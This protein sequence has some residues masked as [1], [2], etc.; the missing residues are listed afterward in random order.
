[1]DNV[2]FTCSA[3]G[4]PNN[5][6]QWQHNNLSIDFTT[7]S[8]TIANITISDGGDYTCIVSN[9]A[10][11]ENETALLNILPR[12]TTPPV[13]IETTNGSLVKFF[14][15]AEGFPAPNITFQRENAS[16][17][18]ATLQLSS[19]V[20]RDNANNTVIATL[21]FSPVT[22]GDEGNYTCIAS[23]LFPVEVSIDVVVIDTESAIL[24]S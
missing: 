7:A 11:S 12:I 15:E 17:P 9:V 18:N 13:N 8:I 16:N 10:G 14:C 22:F 21:T 19:T 23:P 5:I 6:F 4:G 2:T 24:T 20:E 1:M 3:Q